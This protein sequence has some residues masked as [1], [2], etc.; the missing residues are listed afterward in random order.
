MV[1]NNR[2]E[3]ALFTH[4]FLPGVQ[5]TREIS[6]PPSAICFFLSLFSISHEYSPDGGVG[7]RL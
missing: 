6:G 1:M 5:F 7:S 3:L 2:G 4:A